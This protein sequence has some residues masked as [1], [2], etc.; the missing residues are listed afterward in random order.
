M[1]LNLSELL[2]EGFAEAQAEKMARRTATGEE[3]EGVDG[4]AVLSALLGA[5]GNDHE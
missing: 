1:K 2:A 4:G 5:T 3:A